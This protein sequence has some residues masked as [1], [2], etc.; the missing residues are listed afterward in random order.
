MSASGS[1]EYVIQVCF[2]SEPALQ[3]VRVYQGKLLG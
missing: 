1:Y 2:K 3:E